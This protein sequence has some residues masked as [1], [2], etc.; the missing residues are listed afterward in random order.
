MPLPVEEL[1]PDSG[2]AT[3]RLAVSKSIAKLIREGKDQKQAAGQAYAIAEEKIGRSL[4]KE[5]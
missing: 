3:I 2:R 1:T 5:A 4:G